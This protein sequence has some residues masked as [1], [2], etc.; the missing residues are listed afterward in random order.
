M[1]SPRKCAELAD[2]AGR[3]QQLL[4]QVVAQL[5]T[6]GAAVGEVAADLVGVVVQIGGD[7]GDAVTAQQLEHVLHDG[8]VEDGHH[9]LGGAAGERVQARAQAG[10]HDHGFDAGD[11]PLT[12]RS[13]AGAGAG[14]APPRRARRS[15]PAS[16]MMARDVG[17]RRDVEGR[18]ARARARRRHLRGRGRR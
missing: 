18:V 6:Q 17:R 14:Q 15:T 7:L 16:V 9:G 2:A 3:A 13:S 5:D 8:P 1:S 4:F 12:A 11:A 10:G